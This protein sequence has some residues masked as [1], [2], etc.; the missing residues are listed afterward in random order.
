VNISRTTTSMVQRNILADLNRVNAK[1]SKTQQ[2]AASGRAINRP[3]DNPYGTARSLALSGSLAGNQQYQDNISDARGWQDATEAAL[4][5]IT[6]YVQ[7]AQN[8]LVQ[9]SADT[10]DQTSRNAAA[11][12]I[13]QIIQ[14]I[15]TD[16]NAK[17]NGSYIFA[18]TATSTA[19]YAMGAD[20]TYKGDTGGSTASP[21]VAG[22]LREIGPGVTLSI[23]SVGQDFLGNGQP[24]AGGTSDDKLLD[25]LRDVSA[26]LR[27]GDGASLRGTDMTRLDGNLDDVLAVRARNGAQSNR[28]DAAMSRLQDLETATTKQLSDTQDADFTQTIMDL[29]T[30]SAA[31]Q[32]A[33]RAGATIVQSSLMDFLH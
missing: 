18:G 22:V 14:G 2:Q 32:A 8:L 33:L 10:A 4:N 15:K 24:A 31:Y 19:P 7:R 23:N 28:L 25:V 20:D 1:L 29:N 6:L 21:G 30:Q 16:A 12:E 3:S 9:G 26:H 5:S 27:A 17:Y 13:D 11:D